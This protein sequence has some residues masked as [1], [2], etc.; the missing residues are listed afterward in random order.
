MSQAAVTCRAAVRR[1]A[2]FSLRSVHSGGANCLYFL[3]PGRPPAFRA[4]RAP[5]QALP[6]QRSCAAAL[7]WPHLAQ[8][9]PY[10]RQRP[11]SPAA[12]LA[13]ARYRLKLRQGGAAGRRRPVGGGGV[14]GAAPARDFVAAM[15][16]LQQADVPNLL[17]RASEYVAELQR[18]IAEQRWVRRA[19]LRRHCCTLARPVL[20]RNLPPSHRASRTRAQPAAGMRG[21]GAA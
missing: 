2:G 16:A 9:A 3:W 14:S 10:A 12:A 11:P 1:W 17:A 7:A 13:S 5:S 18:Q 8:L 4:A 21:Q 19:R 6:G 20:R 15:D